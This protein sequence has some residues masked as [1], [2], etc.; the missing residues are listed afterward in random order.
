MRSFLLVLFLSFSNVFIYGQTEKVLRINFLNPA[1]EIELSTGNK[2]TFSAALGV[3]YGGGYPDLT[4][5][6]NGFIYII[7]PFVDLQEKFYYN[8]SKREQKGKQTANNSG[9]FI[10]LRFITRGPSLA[11]NVDRTSDIDFAFGPTWGLQRKLNNNLHLLFDIGPQYYFDT[12]GNGNIWPIMVQ[13][14]LGIDL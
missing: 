8:L 12:E 7:T 14:N 10:S 9:N 13:I 5:N 2:S 1:V 11:S 3:G 4:F 6:G